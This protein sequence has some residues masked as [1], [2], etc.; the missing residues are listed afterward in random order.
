MRGRGIQ[1][2]CNEQC[3]LAA[4]SPKSAGASCFTRYNP[5]LLFVLAG[6]K[7]FWLQLLCFWWLTGS[8]S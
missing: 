3:C 4:G 1:V 7:H 5:S 6:L 2:R 8:L